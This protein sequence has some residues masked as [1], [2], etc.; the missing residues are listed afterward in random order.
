MRIARRL[1]TITVAF[2]AATPVFQEVRAGGFDIPDIG[3]EAL[4]RGGTFVAKA[5]SPLALYYNVAGMA[6]QRG[7]RFL[8][9]ANLVFN[10]VSFTR[11]G[12]YSGDPNDPRTPYA[13]K[14]YPEVS[15]SNIGPQPFIGITTDFN[16]FKRWTFGLAIF[17]PPGVGARAFGQ[18]RQYSV[19]DKN[20]MMKTTTRY[21]T[22][23]PGSN[24]GDW[25]QPQA[26][27][28]PL[29]S[30]FDVADQNIL[31]LTPS[32]GL[33]FAPF[34][35]LDLGAAMTWVAGEASITKSAVFPGGRSQC[36]AAGDNPDCDRF[37]TIH[38]TLSTYGFNFSALAHPTTWLDVGVTY[39][40]QI[41]I[42]ASGTATPLVASDGTQVG[43]FPVTLSLKLPHI[44]RYGVRIVSRYEDGTERGDVELDGTFE[45]WR[46]D[47]YIRLKSYDF[48]PS[49]NAVDP[50]DPHYDPTRDMG[51]PNYDPKKGPQNRLFVDTPGQFRDTLSLRLGGAYNV[52]LSDLSRF[53]LRT[54]AYFDSATTDYKWTQ[55]GV[56][57]AAKYGFTF[58]FGWKTKGFTLNFA[59]AGVYMPDRNVTDSA[60]R[61]SAATHGTEYSPTDANLIVGNGL[62][63]AY[64]HTLSVGF[65]VNFDEYSRT[66]LFAN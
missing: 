14:P 7:T 57:S 63:K 1:L 6:R 50:S 11:A 51:N 46:V 59:Y 22:D 53:T 45:N 20:G 16:Y 9:D 65:T 42:D 40:P 54:G 41:N 36:G 26:M 30:R 35:Y 44:L 13:G 31:F 5:D 29:P 43:P 25:N 55:L 62:Y 17:A 27:R 64:I 39:R 48:P 56:F 38:G 52:R 23:I 3:T 4:G 21:E 19:L 32:L 61:A 24:N 47:D 2:A 60:I 66:L 15:G 8:F 28:A 49:G 58:G 10:G 33:A 18:K 34:K 37:S 12:S